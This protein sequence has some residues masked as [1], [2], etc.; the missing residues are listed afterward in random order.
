MRSLGYY[1]IQIY[2]PSSLIVVLS[3]VSF[4]LD[5]N[6]APARVA[7]GITTVLTLTTFI[8]ST[9][10]SLP[11][12]SYLKSIDVYLVTCFIMVFSA[13]LEYAAVSFIGNKP[14]QPT[15]K[16]CMKQ[17]RTFQK[18]RMLSNQKKNTPE[19]M[20]LALSGTG[21]IARSNR[22]KM[23]QGRDDGVSEKSKHECINRNKRVTQEQVWRSI[24][25]AKKDS[26][27]IYCF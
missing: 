15:R 26:H 2:V 25:N 20:R 14:Y 18:Q 24:D 22:C 4:W 21:L 19:G 11:K 8:S 7:L 5:R 16:Q 3:W 23:L 13:L 17:Q 6:A 12:I 9:N 27:V 1:I 10:A